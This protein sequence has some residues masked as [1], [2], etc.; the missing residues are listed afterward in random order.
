MQSISTHKASELPLTVR[1]AVEELLGRTV[2]ADEEITVVAT[3]RQDVEPSESRAAIARKLED[4]LNL[5]AAKVKD[6]PD[7]E[8]DDAI[9]EAIDHVRHRR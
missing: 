6:V 3:P 9:D 2:E 1:A 5:R 7:Q 8:L 4:L